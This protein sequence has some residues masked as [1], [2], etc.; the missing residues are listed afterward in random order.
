LLAGVF[1][2]DIETLS[3]RAVM[4]A[5]VRFE[6]E[7]GSLIAALQ[8]KRDA[9]SEPVF[10]SLKSG[11]EK[12]IEQIAQTLPA[13]AVR[14]NHRVSSLRLQDEQW[15]IESAGSSNIFDALI[16]ATPADV[17]RRLLGPIQ[18]EFDSLL[19]IDATSAIVVALGF[20]AE[21]AK[22]LRIPRGFGYLVPQAPSRVRRPE[23]DPQLLACTFVD[24]KFTHRA[25]EGAVLLR[26]FFGGDT[27]PGLLNDDDGTL[28]SLAH[29]QLS[30][31]LG[32]LPEPDISLVRRWP[33][34]LP[35]YVVGHLDRVTKLTQ[36]S[37]SF[38]GL[39]LIGNAYHGVGLPDLI[40]EGR[41]AG[42]RAARA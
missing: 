1:G 16:V 20:S 37:G 14:L 34:S 26:G 31:A 35:Q 4:P 11:L 40:R 39:Y 25:P 24:Q 28:V 10:S 9:K 2:G 32:Q 19:T 38:P 3:V 27:A 21:H 15:Q 22:H 33:L 18:A 17:T 42:R 13:N 41:E 36:L 7:H 23:D 29:R 6:R 30:R 12:L 8:Q 5:F